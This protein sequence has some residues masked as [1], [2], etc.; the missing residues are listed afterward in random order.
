MLFACDTERKTGILW[1]W[2]GHDGAG[3]SG[4]G[5]VGRNPMDASRP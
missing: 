1:A 5:S 3:N 2:S 4:C